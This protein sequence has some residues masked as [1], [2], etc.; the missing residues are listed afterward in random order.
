MNRGGGAGVY[1]WVRGASVLNGG[2]KAGRLLN[3]AWQEGAV[4]R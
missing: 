4:K 2:W 1:G 3:V